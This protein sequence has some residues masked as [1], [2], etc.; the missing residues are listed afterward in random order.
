MHSQAVFIISLGPA[1]LFWIYF[2]KPGTPRPV[3]FSDVDRACKTLYAPSSMLKA[4][5]AVSC[6]L[7]EVGGFAAIQ[8]SVTR[9]RRRT[10]PT[11][12]F[13]GQIAQYSG[14]KEN[15]RRIALSGLLQNMTLRC[16]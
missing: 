8:T 7:D 5:A 1:V 3:I 16:V 14:R 10:E 12:F 9:L 13:Q 15:K 2:N 4:R 11:V 6:R